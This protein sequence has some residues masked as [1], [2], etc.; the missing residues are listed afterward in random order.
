MC[1]LFKYTIFFVSLPNA[2][3]QSFEFLEINIPKERSLKK[4][5]LKRTCSLDTMNKKRI[6]NTLTENQGLMTNLN[7]DPCTLIISNLLSCCMYLRNLVIKTS[8]LRPVK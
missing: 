6:W 7:P 4:L 1:F 2:Y 3:L 5:F 8:M